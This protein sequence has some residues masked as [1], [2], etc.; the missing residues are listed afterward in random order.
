MPVILIT[1]FFT[2]KK[3]HLFKILEIIGLLRFPKGQFYLICN[4]TIF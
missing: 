3:A 2:D 4:H 1:Q